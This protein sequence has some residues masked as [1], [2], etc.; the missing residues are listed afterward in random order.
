MWA[1]VFPSKR[2]PGA[3]GAVSPQKEQLLAKAD[4][5][6]HGA[7]KAFQFPTPSLFSLGYELPSPRSGPEGPPPVLFSKIL[8]SL[9]QYFPVACDLAPWTE[10][11]LGQDFKFQPLQLPGLLFVYL[12]L[13]Y[14][15]IVTYRPGCPGTLYVEQDGSECREI[16]L[17]LPIKC[18]D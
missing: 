13:I 14:L 7:R 15:H 4:L 3:P 18:W 11:S 1:S 8:S 16:P 6:P 12:M 2:H 17:P 10:D 5:R 9:P